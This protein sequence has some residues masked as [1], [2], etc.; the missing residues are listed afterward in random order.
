MGSMDVTSYAVG[1]HEVVLAFVDDEPVVKYEGREF[2]NVSTLMEAIPTLGQ[3]SQAEVFARIINFLANGFEFY[4]LRSP[5]DAKEFDRERFGVYD[6]SKVTQPRIEN[7]EL[8]FYVENQQTGVPYEV[9]CPWPYS[10]KLPIRY[11]TL[12]YQSE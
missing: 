6:L 3:E 5:S 7:R 10:R 4:F 1:E 9:H 8:I 2:R 12:E 11:E